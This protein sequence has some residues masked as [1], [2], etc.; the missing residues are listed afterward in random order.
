MISVDGLYE[1]GVVILEKKI[2]IKNASKFIVTFPVDNL[3]HDF[4]RL[5]LNDFSFHKSREKSKRYTG[6]ISATVI[7]ERRMV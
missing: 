7:S 2:Q 4:K 3:F 5:T 1:N 6:S